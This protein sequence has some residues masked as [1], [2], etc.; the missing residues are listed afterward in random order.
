L[1]FG[2]RCHLAS[3]WKVCPSMRGLVWLGNPSSAIVSAWPLA[4]ITS[5]VPFGGTVLGCLCGFYLGTIGYCR[6]SHYTRF[7]GACSCRLSL[8]IC[9]HQ[10]ASRFD[11][12]ASFA[13][14]STVR[15]CLPMCAFTSD[16][17]VDQTLWQQLQCFGPLI[18]G[19]I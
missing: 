13:C 7:C 17:A 18:S 11:C 2:P 1:A 16:V 6:P 15:H 19:A 8:P 14:M 12:L 5:S 9:G 4:I 3:L 10:L